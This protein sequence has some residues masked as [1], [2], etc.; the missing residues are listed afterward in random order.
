MWC[1]H[2]FT[3]ATGCVHGCNVFEHEGIEPPCIIKI[4]MP[5][6]RER[7]GIM[8]LARRKE[9]VT[10]WTVPV[11]D[12]I[13]WVDGFTMTEFMLCNIHQDK[14]GDQPYLE[15]IQTIPPQEW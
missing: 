15:V 12:I 5:I 8:C 9:D 10:Y 1:P 13:D 11:V 6:D 2:A 7:P 14:P 3:E 4:I